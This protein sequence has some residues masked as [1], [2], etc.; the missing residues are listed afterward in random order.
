MGPGHGGDVGDDFGQHPGVLE[1]DFGDHGGEAG[2]RRGEDE[3]AREFRELGSNVYLNE[4]PSQD[5]P[6]AP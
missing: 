3:M 4:A 1:D 5:A 6:A 2:Y